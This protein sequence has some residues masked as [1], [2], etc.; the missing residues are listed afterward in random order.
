[1]TLALLLM[2]AMTIISSHYTTPRAVHYTK[3]GSYDAR[4]PRPRTSSYTTCPPQQAVCGADR[5]LGNVH[6][7][8]RR[9]M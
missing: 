7:Y 9:I 4:S 6:H 1:M 2:Y 8:Q 5:R 3:H